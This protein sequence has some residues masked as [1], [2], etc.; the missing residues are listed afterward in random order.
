MKSNKE[1][2]KIAQRHLGEN[3]ARF[4]KFAGLPNGASWCNAFVDYIA[5]QG[6]VEKLYFNGKKETYC[7]HSIKWCKKHL[8]QIPI[9]LAL[10]MDIIYFDWE[11]NGKPNHIGLVVHKKSTT[12]IRTI[13]GNTYKAYFVLIIQET[14]V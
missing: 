2:L 9:Y 4:R 6:D 5:A 1:V 10:P 7:P 13:E 3:G 8:A 11:R 12:E 14:V